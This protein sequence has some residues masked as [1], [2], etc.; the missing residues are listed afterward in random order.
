MRVRR[1][2]RPLLT[3][4]VL[5]AV[6]GVSVSACGSEPTIKSLAPTTTMTLGRSHPV[7]GGRVS[8]A[9]RFDQPL[10]S[11]T[12]PVWFLTVSNDGESSNLTFSS[13]QRGEVVL[14]AADGSEVYRWS[15][16]RTFIQ[17]VT[18]EAIPTG[19]SLVYEL[20]DT[21]LVAP[22]GEYD[23]V[24]SVLATPAIPPVRQKVTVEAD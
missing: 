8:L 4:I 19:D 9:V 5:V 22:P 24:A 7:P 20:G 15:K 2:A 18:N 21:E 3:S 6:L 17:V 12:K 23:L 1:R 10:R 14:L 16:E 11:G 13:G